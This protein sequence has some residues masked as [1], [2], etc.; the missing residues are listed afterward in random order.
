MG[1]V[2]MGVKTLRRLLIRRNQPYAVF[3]VEYGFYVHS[4]ERGAR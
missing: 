3:G 2:K 1:S 4:T